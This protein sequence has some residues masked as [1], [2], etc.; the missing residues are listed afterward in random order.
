[1]A[2]INPE[3]DRI[4]HQVV[5][6][7]KERTPIDVAYLVGSHATGSAREGSDIDI[8]AFGPEIDKMDINEKITLIARVQ[9]E[10]KAPVEIH[11][12]DSTCLKKARPTNI[13]GVIVET[14]DR[15][16]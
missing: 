4:L 11:L 9:M 13:Y 15:I 16:L 7:L 6:K 14:G 10:V 12:F 3:I 8:G 5:S 1:M 2:K